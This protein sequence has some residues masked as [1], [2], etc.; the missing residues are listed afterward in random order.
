MLIQSHA[1]SESFRKWSP[2]IDEDKWNELLTK[3]GFSGNQLVFHDY[4]DRISHELSAI[5]STAI[6]PRPLPSVDVNLVI[7]HPTGQDR[8]AKDLLS[9]FSNHT[10]IQLCAMDDALQ[11]LPDPG[12]V[13]IFL[14]E[15]DQPIWFNL[16]SDQF[17]KLHRLLI[18]ASKAVWVGRGDLECTA[19]EFRLADGL[20]R[21]L[22]SERGDG[23]LVL[24]SLEHS[25]WLTS[26]Q[27]IHIAQ[28]SQLLLSSENED[29]EY[30]EHKGRLHIPRLVEASILEE[31][32]RD[33][34]L[35][36]QK[37]KA[38]FGGGVPLRLIVGFPGLLDTLH[39]IEDNRTCQ[40]LHPDE[41]EVQVQSVGL[42]FRDLLIALGR[43]DQHSPG[44]ECVGIV[45]RVGENC[46]G[47]QVGMR[48][49]SCCLD[50]FGTFARINHRAAAR[51]PDGVSFQVAAAV[52]VN[53]TTA[54]YAFNNVA[55]VQ[56]GETVLVHSGAGGTGQAAIQ[57]AQ[58]MGAVVY[59]TV[60]TT[61]KKQFLMDRYGIHAEHIFSSRDVTFA[62]SIRRLTAGRGVDVILNSLSGEAL[63]ASWECIAPYGRFVEIG[64]RDI[65]ARGQLQMFHFARNATFSALDIAAMT[66]ERPDLVRETFESFFPL[67]EE[68]I[69]TPPEPLSVYGVSELESVFRHMQTGKNMGK[70]V[71]EMRPDD[72]V[73]VSGAPSSPRPQFLAPSS[74]ALL[75]LTDCP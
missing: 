3:T 1:G 59:A 29:T 75:S 46:S 23:S 64:K 71:V 58:Y 15:L 9:Y 17:D 53:Y 6:E 21:V 5:V 28:V 60:S 74:N 49:G 32:I 19:P 18:S 52:L 40:P 55:H 56:P 70:V 66:L 41:L 34:Q 50:S 24:L 10:K 39:F 38:P 61:E 44:S 42:N 35:P 37:R 63:A 43:L 22:N 65:Y 31:T 12:A 68:G 14:L 48:V 16:T 57:V 2:C 30:I 62:Q 11:A 25:G 67:I 36:R 26:H 7:I 51:I 27:K 72:M 73:Q 54:W 13:F 33:R 20:F 69:L 45:T 47:F 8:Q 4:E